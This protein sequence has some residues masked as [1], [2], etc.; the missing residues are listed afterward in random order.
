MQFEIDSAKLSYFD[1]YIEIGFT[2]SYV[3]VQ[4]DQDWVENVKFI[5]ETDHSNSTILERN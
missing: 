3:N 4:R 5:M 1:G 2:H